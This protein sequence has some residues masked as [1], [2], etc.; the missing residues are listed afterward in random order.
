M[1][2]KQ[3]HSSPS[4]SSSLVPLLI[5]LLLLA[6]AAAVAYAVYTVATAVAAQTNEKMERKN[7]VVT[8]DGM[9]VGVRH[10]EREK[11]GDRTQSLLVKVWNSASWPV[12]KTG[13]WG[14]EQEQP[15]R[16]SR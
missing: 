10:V 2:Q 11:E 7:V 3:K 12:G 1:A 16:G 15:R 8:K 9:K 6:V 13:F 4:S 14:K 5:L